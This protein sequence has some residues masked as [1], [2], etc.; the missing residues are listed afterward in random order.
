[1]S[2]GDRVER[3]P[4]GFKALAHT[5]NSPYAA[6]D[7]GMNRFYA[8]QFHPEVAHTQIGKEVLGNFL[9]HVCQASGTWNMRSF[10]EEAVERIRE[11]VTAGQVI[12][13]LSGGVDS[14]VTAALLLRAV[15]DRAVFVF[16]DNGLL[17]SGERERVERV[18]RGMLHGD[19]RVIDASERFLQQL[20]GVTDPEEKRRIQ[21]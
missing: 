6:I 4:D 13:A 12:C 18:F 5:S 21:L 20:R 11:Q 3:L 2:H 1:M 19:L 9:F 10:I 8:L 16:V 17:R 14:S 15:P 7:Q